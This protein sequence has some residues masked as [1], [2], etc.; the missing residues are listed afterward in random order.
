MTAEACRHTD[1]YIYRAHAM[2]CTVNKYE[3]MAI[4]CA[5]FL[6][7]GVALLHWHI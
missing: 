4:D 7:L 3:K 2:P 5:H 6:L 1:N